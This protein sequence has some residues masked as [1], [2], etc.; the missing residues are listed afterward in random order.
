MRGRQA[1]TDKA[2]NRLKGPS[3]AASL[4]KSSSLPVMLME[5]EGSRKL[6]LRTQ[7]PG[8]EATLQH[9]RSDRNSGGGI[10][11]KGLGI[12]WDSGFF[13]KPWLN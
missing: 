7:R 6:P 12:P 5:G 10:Q 8:G 2:Q 11:R 3:L 9:R 4:S 13:R 1:D